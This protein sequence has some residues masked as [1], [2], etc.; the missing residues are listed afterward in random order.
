MGFWLKSVIWFR[1]ESLYWGN[2]SK[3]KS[4]ELDVNITTW[5][6]NT[7]ATWGRSLRFDVKWNVQLSSRTCGFPWGPE[8]Q[9]VN[10]F[11]KKLLEIFFVKDHDLSNSLKL[12]GASG[13]SSVGHHSCLVGSQWSVQGWVLAC[14]LDMDSHSL[15][16]KEEGNASWVHHRHM[17]WYYSILAFLRTRGVLGIEKSTWW[18]IHEQQFSPRMGSDQILYRPNCWASVTS[19]INM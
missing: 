9:P 15:Q 5:G 11:R 1:F 6:M 14:R 7:F 16:Q 18:G 3:E 17:D 19:C 12:R 2:L 4:N 10:D 8:T 13:W